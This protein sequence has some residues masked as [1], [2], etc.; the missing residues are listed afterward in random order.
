MITNRRIIRKIT[1]RN[2]RG[3]RE[4]EPFPTGKE[5]PEAVRECREVSV[6][7]R[8]K[9]KSRPWGGS[10]SI[11]LNK[12]DLEFQSK[13][14]RNPLESAQGGIGAAVFETA[15][16]GLFDS[17]CLGKIILCHPQTSARFQNGFGYLELGSHFAGAQFPLFALELGA[18]GPLEILRH[19]FM[20]SL[21]GGLTALDSG[22]TFPGGY[23]FLGS[24]DQSPDA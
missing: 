6:R 22:G 3:G 5:K 2:K 11:R 13:A 24:A 21:P 18:D 19:G 17:G 12:S 10:G 1:I 8:G 15:D 4:A 14:S 7:S 20:H 16:G 9:E 23:Q